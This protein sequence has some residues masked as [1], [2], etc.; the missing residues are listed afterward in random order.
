MGFDEGVVKAV[1]N[2]GM[3]DLNWIVD[4]CLEES[5]DVVLP[6]KQTDS[7]YLEKIVTPSALRYARQTTRPP[8]KGKKS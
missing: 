1:L 4:Q 3:L 7:D 5:P 8:S 6:L 2:I